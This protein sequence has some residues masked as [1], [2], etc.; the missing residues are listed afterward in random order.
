ML[1]LIRKSAGRLAASSK[2]FKTSH[3]KVNQYSLPYC[4][5]TDFNFK[6]SHVKV[7]P[8][9][10]MQRKFIMPI[11]KHPMLKLIE[12]RATFK[13]FAINISKHPMLKLILSLSSSDKSCVEISKHPMLKL[14]IRN[15]IG[16]IIV[17]QFQNIPC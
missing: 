4:R 10:Q 9:E 1:K 7:N 5:S 14:I 2:Y 15:E 6:T 3:V 13:E 16:R 8:A 11:P 12:R 17:M